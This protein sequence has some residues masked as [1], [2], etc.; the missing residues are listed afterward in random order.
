MPHLLVKEE[1]ALE[2]TRLK[3]PESIRDPDSA[4]FD[5]NSGYCKICI[6]AK[7]LKIN[8]LQGFLRSG[9]DSNPRPHA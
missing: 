3:I 6:K 8:D 1:Y 9:R 7:A 5:E 2:I 4:N